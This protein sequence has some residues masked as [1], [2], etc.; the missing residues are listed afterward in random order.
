MNHPAVTVCRACCT[1]L[2]GLSV[3]L[4]SLRVLE[5]VNLHLHCGELTAI[6]GPNGAGKT[7]L[8][9]AMMGLVPYRGSIRFTDAR[10]GRQ[11]V[12]RMGYVP[13][14]LAIERMAPVTVLDFWLACQQRRPAFLPPTRSQRSHVQ[15]ALETVGAEGLADRRMGALSGGE[16]QRVLLSLALEPKPDLLLLDEPVSGMD[17]EGLQR[18]YQTVDALRHAMDM[19]ILLITHDFGMVRHYADRAVLL[20][21]TVR[22]QGR[23]ETVLESP[24]FFELFPGMAPRD[25]GDSGRAVLHA[26]R[27]RPARRTSRSPG[28]N[29]AAPAPK[30]G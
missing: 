2:A 18:F 25:A 9:K 15:A 13:Q 16:T 28:E 21:R 26:K 6:I 3:T 30:G 4:E 8:F 29:V 7:T 14:H 11:R 1:Q 23:P 19:S 22:A 20:D 10:N 5:D 24:A 17:V 12:P 27:R